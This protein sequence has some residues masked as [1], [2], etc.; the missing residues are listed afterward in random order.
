MLTWPRLEDWLRVTWVALPTYPL[1]GPSKGQL[2]GISVKMA[3]GLSLSDTLSS[4][5]S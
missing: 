1:Q 5:D 3:K 2:Q 4:V